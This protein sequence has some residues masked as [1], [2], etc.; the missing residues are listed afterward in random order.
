LLKLFKHY[1]PLPS[2]VIVVIYI[3]SHLVSKQGRRKINEL[4]IITLQRRTLYTKATT[5]RQ[6]QLQLLKV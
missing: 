1:H 4:P 2:N 6:F 3:I 5:V